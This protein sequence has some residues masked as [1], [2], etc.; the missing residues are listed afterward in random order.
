MAGVQIQGDIAAF[1]RQLRRLEEFNRAELSGVL[2]EAMRIS[3]LQ[4]FRTGKSPEGQRWTESRRVR[5]TGGKTLLDT[6]GLRNSIHVHSDGSGF[7]VGSNLRYAATHQFGDENRV[8]RVK[9]AGGLRFRIGN[10]WVVRR[11]VR[12]TIPARP[13]LGVSEEDMAEIRD[14][15]EAYLSEE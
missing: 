7:A 4:R 2:G 13:F 8:I 3:T 11:A 5:E 9:S 14:I 1:R 15:I 12:V 6:A 10:T